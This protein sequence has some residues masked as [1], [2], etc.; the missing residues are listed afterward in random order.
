MTDG[1]NK[2][3]KAILD[4][5]ERQVPIVVGLPEP[6][7]SR[8][9]TCLAYEYMLQDM[10]EKAFNLL[11]QCDPNYFKQ[12]MADDM[13]NDPNMNKIVMTILSKLI[14]IGYVEVRTADGEKK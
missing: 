5:V 12:P 9:L 6:D 3:Q 7:R 11:E 14:E 10:E 13:K 2:Q 4:E 8:C 1:L